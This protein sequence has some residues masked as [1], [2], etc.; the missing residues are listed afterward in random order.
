MNNDNTSIDEF[1]CKC[2]CT[3]CL[4]KNGIDCLTCCDRLSNCCVCIWCSWIDLFAIDDP[5]Y[6]PKYVLPKLLCCCCWCIPFLICALLYKIIKQI[7][8]VCKIICIPFQILFN[9]CCLA[10]YKTCYSLD[11]NGYRVCSCFY[12]IRQ[13]L[14]GNEQIKWYDKILCCLP[15]LCLPCYSCCISLLYNS[16]RSFYDHFMI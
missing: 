11:N 7:I 4:T 16:L 13:G 8:S 14:F 3:P 6:K 2:K 1:K 9:C 15:C 5:N 10:P 12:G